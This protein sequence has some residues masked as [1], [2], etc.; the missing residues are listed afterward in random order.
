MRNPVPA[1]PGASESGPLKTAVDWYIDGDRIALRLPSGD[2]VYPTASE[3]IG[4]E[5]KGRL[6]IRGE[7]IVRRPSEALSDVRF[8]RFP[9]DIRL[10]VIP[11]SEDLAIAP[12]CA[13]EI[14]KGA[15]REIGRAHV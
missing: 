15:R 3:I 7:A 4:A 12:S 11:P 6:T 10:R 9:L 2:T 14:G 5:Y 1:K 13:I 8:A